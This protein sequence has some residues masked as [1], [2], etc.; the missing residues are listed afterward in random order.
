VNAP[1]PADRNGKAKT[2]PP[3]PSFPRYAYKSPPKP[4]AGDRAAAE[5]AFAQ[6]YQAYQAQRYN[7]AIQA[8]RSA[9]QLDP[10]FYN[11]HY[12]LALAAAEAGSQRTA[13]AAYEQALVLQPD[14]IDARY[15]FA[16]LLKQSGY[17]LDAAAQLETLLTRYPN[18][19]RSHLALGNLCAQSLNQP[20]KAREHYLRVLQADPRNPQAG[21][22]HYWLA[23]HPK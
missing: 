3:T 18:D 22:I 23:E 12:N 17:P 9:A 15:N 6:G 19:T 13:L 20:D 14:S 5:R 21:A 16:L 7:E 2:S 11:A 1:N 10:S 8:Y 4:R